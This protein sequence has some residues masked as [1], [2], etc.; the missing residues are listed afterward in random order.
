MLILR[1]FLALLL[2]FPLLLNALAEEVFCR[3]QHDGSFRIRFP[4][5]VVSLELTQQPATTDAA[6][7]SRRMLVLTGDAAHT[8]ETQWMDQDTLLIRP[9][10]GTPA[11]T[12]FRLR[13]KPGTTYLSGREVEATIPEL[14]VPEVLLEALHQI[15]L[16]QGGGV[17]VGVENT[18]NAIA[19]EAPLTPGLGLRFAFTEE[20]DLPL[21]RA[22]QQEPPLRTVSA[23]TEPVYLKHGMNAALLNYLVQQGVDPSKLTEETP[24]PGCV[25]VVPDEPL[26][27]H[28]HHLNTF[29]RLSCEGG[30]GYAAEPDLT[31]VASFP[32][33]CVGLSQQRAEE[34]FQQTAL[35]F[36]FSAPVRRAD[37]PAFFRAMTL[38][39]GSADIAPSAEMTDSA[40]ETE[41]KD[42][43]LYRVLSYDGREIRFVFD[44]ARREKKENLPSAVRIEKGEPT[45]W[46]YDNPELTE[47]MTVL[48]TAA[49]S[50]TVEAELPQGSLIAAMGMGL[51]KTLRHR[52][53]P[54]V[55]RPQVSVEGGDSP[56]HCI[57]LSRHGERSLEL[58]ADSCARVVVSTYRWSPEAAAKHL[59]DFSRMNSVEERRRDFYQAALAD[60]RARAGLEPHEADS[61]SR[62]RKQAEEDKEYDS[63]LRTL[64]SGGEPLGTRTLEVDA[65]GRYATATLPLSM[66]ELAGGTATPGL[67]VLRLRL[68]P[69]LQVLA[70]AQAVGLTEDDVCEEETVYVNI[71]GLCA[72]VEDD[73]IFVHRTADGLVPEG[74][75]V[76]HRQLRHELRNGVAELPKGDSDAWRTDLLLI[77][78]GD[79]TLLSASTSQ[80]ARESISSPAVRVL[81]DRELYRPGETVHL[82]GLQRQVDGAHSRTLSTP[83]ELALHAPN[84]KKLLT[85]TVQ[86]DAYGSFDTSVELPQGEEDVTGQY[87]FRIRRA[88]EAKRLLATHGVNVEVF[89]RDSFELSLLSDMQPVCPDRYR[90]TL[91]AKDYNGAPLAGARVELQLNSRLGLGEAK[92]TSLRTTLTTGEDGSVSYECPLHLL[93]QPQ[94]EEPDTPDVSLQ[95]EASVANDREEVRRISDFVEGSFAEFRMKSVNGLR[96]LTRVTKERGKAPALDYEQRLHGVLSGQKE[97][98][99]PL[100]NGFVKVTQQRDTLW[101]GDI[102]F[103]AND[104]VGQELPCHAEDFTEQYSDLRLCWTGRDAAGH[105]FRRTE[106]LYPWTLRRTP[107][108]E[109]S[110]LLTEENGELFVRAHSAGQ[111]YLMVQNAQGITVHPVR[112]EKGSHKLAL[113]EGAEPVGQCSMALILPCRE[114]TGE[115]SAAE[116]ST[117]T[118]FRKD[119]A[120][121]LTV[122]TEL[123]APALAPGGEQGVRGQVRSARDGSPVK[124]RLLLFAVDE[125]MLS[126]TGQ[127]KELP[128]WERSF[129]LFRPT[130]PRISRAWGHEDLRSFFRHIPREWAGLWQ[131]EF[132]DGGSWQGQEIGI[133]V[134]IGCGL[135]AGDRANAPMLMK[136]AAPRAAK[137]VSANGAE[138]AAVNDAAPM[139]IV[140]VGGGEEEAES[141]LRPVVRRNFTPLAVWSAAAE[142][143]AE[144]RFS[145]TFRVPDTLTRYRLFCAAA[146]AEGDRFGNHETSFEVRQP[147]MLTPGTPFFMSTGDRLLLPLTITN[148]T[149]QEG[150]WQ[151]QLS[152]GDTQ[153]IRLGTKQTGT[154]FF[155]VSPQEE[156]E[157]T[158]RWTA[159]A[160]AGSDAVEGSFPVRFPA[161]LLKE[162]HHLVLNAA[163]E[164]SGSQLSP[165]AL[166][167]P[168]L[169]G[170]ERGELSIELSANPL[171]HLAGFAD[172]VL[173]YPYG[174]TEQVSTGLLPWLMYDRLAPFCPQMAV[175][176]AAAVHTRLTTSI[177]K[178]FRRQT[179][180]GGL[181]YWEGGR[182]SSFWASAHAALI[183]TYAAEQGYDVPQ[184]KMEKLRDYLRREKAEAVTKKCYEH[185]G[186][187]LR[188]ETARALGEKDEMLAALRDAAQAPAESDARPRPFYCCLPPR[189]QEDARLL[190]AL[191]GKAEGHHAAFLTWMRSRGR[192]YR[193]P[194]TWTGAWTLI[195]LREYLGT[196][197]ASSAKAVVR[198]ADGRTMELGNDAVRL[199]LA[200]R[201]Q[202]LG[203]VAACFTAAEGTIYANVVAK[204]QP[205]C[206][207]YPGVTEKGL[208]V[209]RLYEKKNAEGKWQPATDFAV[210]DVVRITLTCAKVAPDLE[211]L[212]LED[213]LPSCMEAV[214]PAIRSQAAGIDFVPWSAAFD[215]KEY[216]ADR[217]RGFCTRW[218][219][220]QLLNMVYFARVKRAG[221][222]TAPP[223]QA[224]LMYEP[225][226]HGLSPNAVIHSR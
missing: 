86:P 1:R 50:C 11:G 207:D 131:G 43:V 81:S 28:S 59:T 154:L 184:D 9:A 185:W 112:V 108:S 20:E 195:A 149:E 38:R 24:L 172:F 186:A 139:A 143:D 193:H 105:D 103:P 217:V 100:P 114:K 61:L 179:A 74:G 117:L 72:L 124:A 160:A 49:E 70:A 76:H 164:G 54:G 148:A 158:L 27:A 116:A 94:E 60:A 192:D 42:G 191:H 79:D 68:H 125:G 55:L 200:T 120:R 40:G 3:P 187:L 77:T 136:A 128:D 7:E 111:A 46:Q 12:V 35:R 4:E 226:T 2:L 173:D 182:E 215:N 88:N 204:A 142:S 90:C 221:T 129:S 198:M 16:P 223:A 53:T 208:Q 71:T 101:E 178:L 210:G 89:R 57:R 220:R 47:E 17:I 32:F 48:V 162:N 121:A 31:H 156:G 37:L 34:G 203:D 63:A 211:Y 14:R 202:K 78:A 23:H 138:D 168:E 21:R 199:T 67:Y 216:L 165:A 82:F 73:L 212:V 115:Y 225:Q 151:V 58:Q 201:G 145:C 119:A 147:V 15:S 64:L 56:F 163:G 180:D 189:I 140:C 96:S 69:T 13:L 133:S 92:E 209:T 26:P 181:A 126:L 157:L 167:A 22:G 155:E 106:H 169:A 84:G 29:W 45:G 41:E 102:T 83:L 214:N 171:L 194:S 10:K 8:P 153:S 39:A 91:T 36:R 30:H 80:R 52:V 196:Q 152:T 98:K 113:P 18:E 166:L 75:S 99:T 174:C 25:L 33:L 51:E 135:D 159:R 44:P 123:A 161:P 219:N 205:P 183:L 177:A 130:L 150:T 176:P 65:Q 144:G 127:T 141:P 110:L 19:A 5:P 97:V 109:G 175:T 206:T 197:P 224:Q 188:Y 107:S 87:T 213:Y 122:T 222:C 93:P 85:R 6:A 134:D 132:K 218:G 137:A 62:S 190:L 146:D 104:T 95:A 66:D 118:I 170:S